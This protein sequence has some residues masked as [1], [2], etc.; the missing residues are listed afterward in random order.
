MSVDGLEDPEKPDAI[1]A[2]LMRQQVAS[3]FAAISG[4]S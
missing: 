2:L 3:G 4:A 1:P